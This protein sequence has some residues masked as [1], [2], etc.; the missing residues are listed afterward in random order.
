VPHSSRGDYVGSAVGSTIP[1]FKPLP[2]PLTQRAL[3]F[4]L[5][6]KNFIQRYV[7]FMYDVYFPRIMIKLTLYYSTFCENITKKIFKKYSTF[8]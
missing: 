1:G 2:R 4:N 7:D 8:V 6:N 3:F 5:Y